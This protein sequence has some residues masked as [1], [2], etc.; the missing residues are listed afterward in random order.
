[1]TQV[2]ESPELRG[3]AG[4]R[5]SPCL[6]SAHA[7]RQKSP[8]TPA[9]RGELHPDWTRVWRPLGPPQMRGAWTGRPGNHCGC[10]PFISINP[11]LVLDVQIGS[12]R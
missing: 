9:A 2:W 3:T 7:N 6:L 4:P 8:E 10:W 5:N 11:S 12:L 1:M